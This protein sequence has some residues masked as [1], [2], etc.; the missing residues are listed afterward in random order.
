[1]TRFAP[2]AL[3]AALAILPASARPDAPPSAITLPG[4]EGIGKGKHVVLL[5]GDQE[6]RSE[7]AIPQLAKI[8]S[9]HHGFKTTSLFTVDKNGHVDPNVN[10]VP[11]LDALKT[12]DLFIIF[13]RFLALPDDQM[14]PIAAYV[15]A[16]KP[17]IGL[18]TSTHAFNFPG[19][20]KSPFAKFGNGSGVKGWQGGFGKVV[21]GEQWVNH[22]GGHG[23]EG[24]RGVSATGQETHPILKGIAPGSIFGTT[25]VYT[26]N[27]PLP[28]CT[29]IVLGEV[30]E[31]LE[32]TSKAVTGQKND[33]MMPVAWTRNYQV[34]DGAKGRAFTTTM[35]AS[36]DLSYEGTRRMVVNGGL[37][38][39]GLESQ[40][41]AVTK[42]DLVGTYSPTRFRN[43]GHK[44]GVTPADLFK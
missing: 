29:P 15:E 34:P 18:R 19:N 24:T 30:T 2:A 4:G 20:S 9:T 10:N 8:L 26:V 14:A 39:L 40:I 3:A 6:Y 11:G 36:E 27:L 17:V 43:P 38:A 13:T 16:G 22:H 44:K 41:P 31:S 1:M 32:S 5:S 28:G 12:A 7:E 23:K 42:V 25:D 35:G 33:P 21:L 37:W